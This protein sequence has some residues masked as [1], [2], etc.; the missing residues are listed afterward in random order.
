MKRNRL[1]YAKDEII[2]NLY[3]VGKEYMM[4]DTDEEYV[5]PY[6]K[7]TTGEVFTEFEWK[8]NI[9]KKLVQFKDISSIQYQFQKINPNIK[10]T[11]ETIPYFTPTPTT[12]DYKK[13]K[14]VRFFLKK[15]NEFK[16][17]EVS[18][19]IYN[20]HSAAEIDPNLY[21]STKIDWII[22]GIANSSVKDGIYVVGVQE[23]NAKT[24]FD[25]E[26]IMPSISKI[27]PDYLQFYVGNTSGVI[28][29]PDI[30]QV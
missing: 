26:L 5:G 21:I 11:Y 10:T 3:T 7:Y 17:I 16:I 4:H 24:V 9:S 29:P 28:V 30:N 13:G 18:E 12:A 27:L 15:I 8:P 23:Q 25:T 19:D 6:H 1:Q 22:S 14:L 2:N 20:K